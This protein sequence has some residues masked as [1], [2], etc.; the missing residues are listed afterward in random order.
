M[1]PKIL[2]SRSKS[3]A[4]A[5]EKAVEAAGGAPTSAYCPQVD[6]SYDGL[7]LCGGED[8]DPSRY[9]QENRGSKDID[10]DR[11]AAEFALIEAYLQAG[12]PILG[13][14]RGHQILN[15]A[16][17]GT[18]IQDL[19]APAGLFH[20]YDSEK[21]TERVHP[22][23]AAPRSWFGETWGDLFAVNSHHHQVAD[24]LGEGFVPMLWS[25]SG[26]VEGML[27]ESRPLLCVQFHPERMCLDHRR[28]D[29]VDGFPIFQKFLQ[30]C[31][32]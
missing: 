1:A 6:M 17:G 2:L 21:E 18:L 19:P 16:L 26:V 22:V 30:M 5:Y 11:D 12:K 15:I 25:E 31:A 27:H 7:I 28:A 32:K 29:T 13:I 4:E 3:S 20:T 23:H 14:C 9:G 8:M 10:L 24:R